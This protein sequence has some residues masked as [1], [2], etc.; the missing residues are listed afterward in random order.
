VRGI[1]PPA[2]EFALFSG[3]AFM[4]A[5]ERHVR[6]VIL[7]AELFAAVLAFFKFREL[8]AT[9][10][11]YGQHLPQILGLHTANIKSESNSI[12][13][14][15]REPQ[16]TKCAV[17]GAEVDLP[18]R[19]N[20]CENFYCPE[21][22]LPENHDCTETWRVKAI[23]SARSMASPVQMGTGIHGVLVPTRTKKMRFSNTEIHHLILGTALVTAA[24]VSFLLG[25]ATSALGLIIATVIFALGFI[26]HELAHK[27]VAQRYGLWAEFRVNTMGVILTA[28]SIV[29]PLKFIAPGAVMISGFADR[30][31]MG[32]TAFAG[33]LVNVVIT[34]ALLA[35]L[36]ILPRPIYS[37]AV[38]YGAAINAFLALFNLIPFSIFDGRKIFVWNKRYWAVIL[39]VSLVLTGYTYFLLGI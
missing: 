25:N 39:V 29:S 18:F 2:P 23:K 17:C 3:Y 38:L 6:W 28:I 21:H 26:L 30:D 10:C 37:S 32:L 35:S 15:Q 14:Q 9:G 12:S 16:P 34:I 5:F 13:A 7:M 1:P 36:P 24:G 8:S 4:T 11:A 22:R 19:C 31:R 33:P 27:Y 20:Y